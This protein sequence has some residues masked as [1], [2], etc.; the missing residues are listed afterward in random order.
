MKNLHTLL[1][2]ISIVCMVFLFAFVLTAC[3]KEKEPPYE[4]LKI[5]DY[6]T[7]IL[8]DLFQVKAGIGDSI[9]ADVKAKVEE[10]YNKGVA[11]INAAVDVKAA[12]AAFDNAKAQIAEQ[13]PLA[14]GIYSFV[15]E[16]NKEKTNITG[17]LEQYAVN[18]GITGIS[19]FE[20][21]GYVMYNP[22]VILGTENYITGY[23]FG[24][25]AEG[26]ITA[27][28]ASENK[29]EWK[30]YWHQVSA[31]DPGTANYFNDQGSEVS[32][33]VSYFTA[34]FY[35][36]F[37]NKTKDGYDWVPELA[38]EKPT[39]VNP[40][41]TG[42]ATIWKFPVRTG[43]DGLKYTTFSTM[44]SRKAFNNRPVELEDYETIFKVLLN[45]RTKW[46][47]GAELAGKKNNAIK[48]AK[49]YYEASKNNAED[50]SKL[51]IKTFEEGGK[52][53]FQVEFENPLSQFYAMYYISS[54]L[55]MPIP[56]SFL[57]LVT[58][59]NFLGYNK[60]KTET[61][62]DNS[63]SLG[64]YALERWDSGQ[65][66]VYK[67]NPNYV[68]ADTKFKIPGIHTNILTA[69]STDNEAGFKEFLAGNTD[70]TGI[71]Q[72][73]LDAYKSDPRTRK[74]TGDSV[75]KLNVNATNEETWEYLFGENGVCCQTAKSDYW[76]VEP[77]LSNKHFVKALSLAINRKEFAESRGSI[78]SVDFLSSNYM[79]DPENGIS[80]A[81][82]D[83]HKKAV[84]GILEDTEEG[85]NL[86]LAREYFKIALK[87]LEAQGKYTPGTKENP[88]VI[89]LEIAWM[90]PQHE[91]AFHNEIKQYFE[92]AFN[93]NTVSGGAYKLEVDFWVGATWD[94]VYYEK[95][96]KGQYDLG[97]GSVSG[98]PLNPLAFFN[99][100]SSDQ[101]ISGN[102]TLNWGTDTNDPNADILVYKGERYSFD[103]LWTA[104][105][106]VGV[107]KDGANEVAIKQ[108]MTKFDKQEDGSYNATIELTPTL[109][110][111]TTV[112]DITNVVLCWYEGGQDGYKEEVMFDATAEANPNCTVEIK[113]TEK[114]GIE[115]V[116]IEIK[117][118]KDLVDA[119]GGAMGIDVYYNNK[120]GVFENTGLY[121]SSYGEFPKVAAE[122][123]AA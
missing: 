89:K 21:G 82:T 53:W 103:A 2:K 74:T 122:T 116:I 6:R 105:N 11:D 86:E 18:N 12:L 13:I 60:N 19:L 70:A 96:M 106:S 44:E 85:Y 30:R 10:E 37:M 43:K 98:D 67:K 54:N 23:G 78:S 97:F 59:D 29:T 91:K 88:T 118:P 35:T 119:Y 117:F 102:F 15:G 49:A 45:E 63:L 73:K 100:L 39:A 47:R 1:K 112:M 36:N 25:L 95:M 46:F 71:P 33:F 38:K 115:K 51:G 83:A 81:T 56:Q 110:E 16:S 48:G 94:E 50:F 26:A 66:V 108:E 99:I 77:A 114:G 92:D 64:A 22:R 24:N 31:A 28:L 123:P 42:A 111:E 87:E 57:D 84:A 76:E 62:V 104:A 32:D 72:T 7:Y 27:D 113:K 68:Y 93:Y 55:Y 109:P 9:S 40:D 75:F 90:Y 80:Y 52:E 14:N 5:E 58:T 121:G 41:K 69:M 101:N 79:S 17:I 20:N 3:N 8:A 4:E 65:Q 61:P 34:S 107:V 120:L